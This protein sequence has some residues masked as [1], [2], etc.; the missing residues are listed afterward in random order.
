MN[1]PKHVAIIPDGNRTWAKAKWFEQ[2]VWHLEWFNR[3]KE[4]ATY[5]F[6]K[7]PI[8]VFTVWW[9]S[10][11]NLKNRSKKELEYLFE[12][13]KMIPKELFDTMKKNRVSFHTAWNMEQLP[14]HL[15]DFLKNKEKELTFTDTD[16]HLFL[17]INYWWQ[18]EILRWIKK[19]FNNNYKITKEN[20]EKCLDFWWFP[21]VE[22]VIRTKQKLAKR[23]SWFM[24]W[25]IWYAQLYFTDLHCPDFTVNEFQ[26]ALIW[27]DKT[28]KTQ[29]YWK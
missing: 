3:T 21:K 23:L 28:V 7:T 12:L 8:K 13:Y 6:E 9:L 29:N 20:F 16:K 22:L 10:T 19:L 11:E 18:D 1:Y 26:K 4:I 15:T 14:N 27:Y 17:A 24:L 2:F 5:I 25:W